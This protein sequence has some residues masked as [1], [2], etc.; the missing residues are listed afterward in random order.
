MLNYQWL[1]PFSFQEWY[2]INRIWGSLNYY[3]RISNP[4]PQEIGTD[5]KI[6]I[7]SPAR[8]IRTPLPHPFFHRKPSWL[9]GENSEWPLREQLPLTCLK[10]PVTFHTLMENKQTNKQT[11]KTGKHWERFSGSWKNTEKI[12]SVMLRDAD[13][14][15]GTS[16]GLELVLSLAGRQSLRT[17]ANIPPSGLLWI[18]LLA[19]GLG[20]PCSKLQDMQLL[21]CLDVSHPFHLQLKGH[22]S[23]WDF[24]SGLKHNC[25]CLGL[26]GGKISVCGLPWS[27]HSF[28]T[29]CFLTTISLWVFIHLIRFQGVDFDHL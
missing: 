6:N 3:S 2:K 28:C 8:D 12:L 5:G 10:S 7:I 23:V 25:P 16:L 9:L 21:H 13:R 27:L 24:V 14:C 22:Q 19:V 1:V 4:Q 20:W 17:R 15:Q 29:S 11:K 18:E 26:R